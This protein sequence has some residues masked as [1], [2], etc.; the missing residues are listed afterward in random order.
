MGDDVGEA[1]SRL[2]LHR[3]QSKHAVVLAGE[4]LEGGVGDRWIERVA[5]E[6]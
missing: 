4:T 2:P 6:S 5:V 3:K 1:H